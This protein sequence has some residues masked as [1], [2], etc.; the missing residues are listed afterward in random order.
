MEGFRT[1]FP[2]L[3]QWE[4]SVAAQRYIFPE[5]LTIFSF[6]SGGREDCSLVRLFF[7]IIVRKSHGMGQFCNHRGYRDYAKIWARITRH[8]LL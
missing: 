8:I 7:D 2:P 1:E 5:R 4:T 3:D 6:H